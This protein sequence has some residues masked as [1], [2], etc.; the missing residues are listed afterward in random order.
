MS[1]SSVLYPVSRDSE[2][3]EILE[4]V[5]RL[6]LSEELSKPDEMAI[7]SVNHPRKQ[8]KFE[9]LSTNDLI[10]D[11][12]IDL[13]H[14]EKAEVDDYFENQLQTDIFDKDVVRCVHGNFSQFGSSL[15]GDQQFLLCKVAVG[16]SFLLQNDVETGKSPPPLPN[17]FQSYYVYPV[18]GDK[19][20]YLESDMD[21]QADETENEIELKRRRAAH[22]YHVFLVNQAERILPCYLVKFRPESKVKEVER[23]CEMQGDNCQ[24]KADLYCTNCQVYLCDICDQEMHSVNKLLQRHVREPIHCEASASYNVQN[25]KMEIIQRR[26]GNNFQH[27]SRCPDHP[28]RTLDYFDPILSKPICVQC[29]MLGSHSVGEAA[30]HKLITIQE[31]YQR[32]VEESKKVDP[33]LG[34]RKSAIGENLSV[35]RDQARLIKK[36]ANEV[37]QKIYAEMRKALQHNKKLA[38]KKLNVL[39]SS[40]LEMVRQL[41]HIEWIESFVDK[42]REKQ[43]PV[44][45]LNAWNRHVEVQ[46]K[47]YTFKFVPPCTLDEVKPDICMG[48]EIYISCGEVKRHPRETQ[49]LPLSPQNV[50]V[51]DQAMAFR[52]A[53]LQD[54]NI[55]PSSRRQ[56]SIRQTMSPT[57][58]KIVS[59][60]S[61][62]IERFRS[63]NLQKE[64]D[65]RQSAITSPMTPGPPNSRF[66]DDQALDYPSDN[67]DVQH[68]IERTAA[69]TLRDHPEVLD[70]IE[71]GTSG[72]FFEESDIID[73][74]KAC[75]LTLALPLSA[76]KMSPAKLPKMTNIYR[77]ARPSLV[78]TEEN[79]LQQVIRTA[80]E[81]KSAPLVFLLESKDH[82]LGA[83]IN[84]SSSGGREEIGFNTSNSRIHI[85]SVDNDTMHSFTGKI[86]FNDERLHF[87]SDQLILTKDLFDCSTT[88]DLLGNNDERFDADAIE[89]WMFE[90]LR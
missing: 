52:R 37:E 28:S 67:E 17:G 89:V 74:K 6:S 50:A 82:V 51:D 8:S 38:Q 42:D 13:N 47:L 23:Q 57:A 19:D 40:E 31:A 14:F 56:S 34:K 26:L 27:N 87:G 72:Y 7:W 12:W 64:N 60:Y 61:E 4:H 29:K 88:R 11:C 22:Y 16:R 44:P 59:Q 18:S 2:D 46:Q 76:L 33:I 83:F 73:P 21:H 54:A 30:T 10:L 80:S 43:A 63:G 65:P 79:V 35:L 70:I 75:A 66:Q 32:A 53:L 45:F 20:E 55:S 9:N 58:E 48:G 86:D 84:E 3:F 49:A 90:S 5:V 36:N 41:R 85:F 71:E 62:Q 69:E 68:S 78:G 39:Q 24:G 25:K 77:W 15:S 1:S 81:N